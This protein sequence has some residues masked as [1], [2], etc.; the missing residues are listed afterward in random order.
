MKEFFK[1]SYEFKFEGE[2]YKVDY[3]SNKVLREYRKALSETED[4]EGEI[5][6]LLEK[7]GLK[8]EVMDELEP[9]DLAEILTALTEK[10]S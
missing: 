5:I 7:L 1:R 4:Q 6:N 9:H 3:P 8:Q 2:I 10:K